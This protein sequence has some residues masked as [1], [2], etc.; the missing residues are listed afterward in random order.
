MADK[1]G[2]VIDVLKVI[3]PAVEKVLERAAKGKRISPQ[4]VSFLLLYDMS[5]RIGHLNG[6]A[7]GLRQEM[8]G[9]HQEMAGLRQD[10]RPL[11]E[12]AA[13]LIKRPKER[14]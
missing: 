10:M 3:A 13:E 9:L 14:V 2:E 5:S 6:E 4:D 12:A 8:C 7:S 11:I 1:M